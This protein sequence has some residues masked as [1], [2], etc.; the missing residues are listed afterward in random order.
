[1]RPDIA[2]LKWGLRRAVA[3]R[4][5]DLNAAASRVWEL[6]PGETVTVP[7][8]IYPDGALERIVAA[9][10][11]EDAATLEDRIR[12][13]PGTHGASRAY[14]I[15]DVDLSGA[16]LYRG[17]A[18]SQPGHGRARPWRQGGARIGLEAAHLV[19]A[20]SG[21]LF[22]GP[23]LRDTLP[24]GLIPEAGAPAITMVGKTYAHAPGYRALVDL[25]CPPCPDAARIGRL[26]VYE[27]FAQNSFK[28][29]RYRTLR[30]RL[31]GNVTDPAR[32]PGV[33][34]K[35]GATGE[36]RMLTNEAEIEAL[37]AGFG[38]D[39]V[40][41]AKLEPAEIARRMTDTPLVISIEGSHLAHAIYTLA[42]NG[43]FLVIQPPD[44]VA[45]PYKEYADRMDMRFGLVV[46]HPAPG[47][48]SADPGEIAAMVE[49][50][51]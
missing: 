35:R 49:R 36:A 9:S 8:A 48:F 19:S 13:G 7:P 27:D 10:P 26:T 18:R 17:A 29:A 28:A 25:P 14:L 1:M 20:W 42:D 43:A 50:L 21:S 47:G 3:G 4:M 51:A 40:E 46:G 6:C 39:I 23:F 12:G 37:L 24:L 44:R 15:E 22:F 41:P 16:Y 11:W 45:L 2:Y 34:L 30:D 33:Y 38:F 32:P 31:R 5:A